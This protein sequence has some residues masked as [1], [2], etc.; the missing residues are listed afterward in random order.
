MNINQKFLVWASK[1]PAT[2]F[3][4]KDIP[5]KINLAENQFLWYVNEN[6][7]RYGNYDDPKDVHYYH[8]TNLGLSKITPWNEKLIIKI[9]LYFISTVI[10]AV[11]GLLIEANWGRFLQY[12][13][14]SF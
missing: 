12:L 2:G 14:N 7:I 5:K 4:V 13:K 6:L 9:F 3:T 11:M 8:I 1:Q 10:V